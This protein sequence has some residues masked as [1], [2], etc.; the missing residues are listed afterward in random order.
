MAGL[1]SFG[2][3]M[4]T[5]SKEI[6]VL[7]RRVTQFTTR[8]EGCQLVWREWGS[9][10]PLLLLHGGYGSWLHWLRNIEVLSRTYRVLVPDMPG[11]GDSDVGPTPWSAE[12]TAKALV[13]GLDTALMAGQPLDAV[14]F[15]MGG[16]VLGPLGALLSERLSHAIFIGPN[17]MQLPFPPLPRLRSLS[18]L[19]PDASP[20]DAANVHRYNLGL[21]M[22]A[23]PAKADDTAVEAHARNVSNARSNTEHVPGSDSLLLAL[24]DVS[25]TLSAIWGAEDVF[26][27]PHMLVREQTLRQFDLSLDF[28]VV[29]GAGHW[30]MYEQPALV[31][32]ALLEMLRA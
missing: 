27:G 13:H 5:E 7:E 26:V 23:D 10:A 8:Y 14:G 30:V 15:S 28:R 3:L 18:R 1:R 24:P 29:D 20:Q 9:G 2:L 12:W 25:A 22:F 31:N 17:G 21:L 19:G 4:A 16:V 6:D 11:H 32:A